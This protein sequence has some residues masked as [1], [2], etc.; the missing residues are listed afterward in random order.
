[1]SRKTVW[2][3]VACAACF[4]TPV[5]CGYLHTHEGR[6]NVLQLRCRV[7]FSMDCTHL[8]HGSCGGLRFVSIVWRTGQLGS[9]RPC[10][11]SACMRCE[12][13]T[14]VSGVSYQPHRVWCCC[15]ACSAVRLVCG[16]AQP[17]R[18]CVHACMVSLAGHSPAPV[19]CVLMHAW[20]AQSQRK[21]RWGC[22]RRLFQ[23]AVF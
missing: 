15:T 6:C 8:W 1:M 10:K 17:P 20:V 19:V 12:C 13:A 22:T 7:C 3:S 11:A 9:A 23:S 14:S 5:V 21:S 18:A 4:A 2:V 16:C